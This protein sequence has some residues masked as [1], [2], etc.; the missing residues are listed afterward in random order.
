MENNLFVKL[1]SDVRGVIKKFVD[2][3]NEIY[4]YLA[5]LKKIVG[6]IKQH[7]FYQLYKFKLDTL[8]INHFIIKYIAY[9]MVTRRILR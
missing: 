1:N 2:R 8:I 7:M 3:C 6:D 5:M 9:G 4:I